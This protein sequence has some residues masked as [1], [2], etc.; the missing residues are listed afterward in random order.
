MA[1]RSRT[2]L[3]NVIGFCS[4]TVVLRTRLAGNPTFR[5]LLM[6]VRESALD[7][8]AH[9]ELP[10]EKIVEA[11]NPER[12]TRTN[13]LFQINFRVVTVGRP[14]LELPGIVVEPV[15]LDPGLARFDLAFEFHLREDGIGGYVRYDLGLFEP[16]TIEDL[17]GDFEHVLGRAL[18]QPHDR[19]LDFDL[20]SRSPAHAGGLEASETITGF[21][22]RRRGS[23]PARPA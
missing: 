6:R 15:K 5:E 16:S 13:P 12:S 4:N 3:E 1:N 14:E 2:E 23:E 22:A 18:R 9:Q 21:R 20:P 8:Y 10:F 11:V 17:I 19:L 7:A